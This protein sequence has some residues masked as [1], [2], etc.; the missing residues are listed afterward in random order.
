MVGCEDM[1]FTWEVVAGSSEL[2]T[3]PWGGRCEFSGRWEGK[4]RRVGC[5]E[6]DEV[7]YARR[8]KGDSVFCESWTFGEDVES[9]FD[10]RLAL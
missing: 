8:G 6:F 3:V 2:G 1:S 10:I 7:A 9:S 5:E 4:C